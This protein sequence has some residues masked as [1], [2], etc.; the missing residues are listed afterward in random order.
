MPRV[1]SM[2]QSGYQ[3]QVDHHW[4]RLT[5]GVVL[6]SLL[7]GTAGYQGQRDDYA[8]RVYENVGMEINRAG[9]RL[10]RNNLSIQPTLQIRPG[11]SINILVNRDLILKPIAPNQSN[12]WEA[13][14]FP[15]HYH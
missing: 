12:A 1:D 8:G 3:D 15:T 9:Q 11:F 5:T 14:L 10:T 2:G 4:G 6:S 13:G 7:A